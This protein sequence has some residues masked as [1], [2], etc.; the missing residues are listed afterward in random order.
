MQINES[1]KRRERSNLTCLSRFFSRSL[2]YALMVSFFILSPLLANSAGANEGAQAQV[3]NRVI[4]ISIDGAS[5]ADFDQFKS[6]ILSNYV[7]KKIS[8]TLGSPTITYPV[9]ASI[10]T[11]QETAAHGILSNVKTD[12]KYA[13]QYSLFKKPTLFSLYPDSLVLRWPTTVGLAGAIP[14]VYNFDAENKQSLVNSFLG[15][16]QYSLSFEMMDLFNGAIGIDAAM[17]EI[18]SNEYKAH[19]LTAVHFVSLDSL[20]HAKFNGNNSLAFASDNKI[21]SMF[22][23]ISDDESVCK[24]VLSDHGIL[25]IQHE[26]AVDYTFAGNKI[27]YDTNIYLENAQ[28]FREISQLKNVLG[29]Q[30]TCNAATF[31]HADGNTFNY[32]CEPPSN[33]IFIYP[34]KAKQFVS[35]K[36]GGYHGISMK[37]D[38]V[39]LETKVAFKDCKT[40][41]A[42]SYHYEDIYGVVN[43]ELASSGNK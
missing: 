6:S 22:S 7:F 39:D 9:H 2:H 36:P 21:R 19:S 26:I 24:I 18:V 20:R 13:A 29:D 38:L 43:K 40:P 42:H 1:T 33:T 32:K 8:S 28:D 12:G 35:K 4:V 16:P 41:L 11:G 27:A 10:I 31:R 3:G 25:E 15:F 23:T 17:A 5:N 30:V 37:A 34:N 14:E